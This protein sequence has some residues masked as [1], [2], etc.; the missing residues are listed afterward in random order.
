MPASAVCRSL[1]RSDKC[2]FE[3]KIRQICVWACLMSKPIKIIVFSCCVPML[4]KLIFHIHRMQFCGIHVFRT[5]LSPSYLFSMGKPAWT[6]E[7]DSWIKD[8]MTGSY[9][10]GFNR[11]F[12]RIHRSIESS[13]Y[14]CMFSIYCRISNVLVRGQLNW[15]QNSGPAHS[16]VWN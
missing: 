11:P 6:I 3:T 15:K 16:T 9:N 2:P 4:I 13:S 5:P 12:C 14:V 7:W 8:F 1:V 10:S